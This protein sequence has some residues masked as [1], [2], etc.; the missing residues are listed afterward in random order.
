VAR[1]LIASSV[2]VVWILVAFLSSCAIGLVFGIYPA[3][4]A[5]NLDPIEAL[6]YE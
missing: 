5:A 3:W 1:L 2:S 4:K 6:R